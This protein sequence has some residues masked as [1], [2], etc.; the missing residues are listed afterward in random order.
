MDSPYQRFHQRP[1]MYPQA[2]LPLHVKQ[3]QQRRNPTFL[4]FPLHLGNHHKKMYVR[5]YIHTI[6]RLLLPSSF[7]KFTNILLP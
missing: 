6:V 1:L 4:F 2:I 3:L 5:A 7:V